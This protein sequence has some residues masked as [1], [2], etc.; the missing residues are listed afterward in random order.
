[1]QDDIPP[2]HRSRRLL[3][4]TL[5]GFPS[6][7]F[8]G[9][10]LGHGYGTKTTLHP[11]NSKLI[12]LIPALLMI[13]LIGCRSEVGRIPFTDTGSGK[14]EVMIDASKDVEFW[15]HLDLKEEGTDSLAEA[16]MAGKDVSLAY[17]ILLY[18]DGDLCS[19]LPAI[20][21]Q[22]APSIGA[23]GANL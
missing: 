16:I 5:L 19:D 6:K 17:S 22:S 15:T 23:Q 18:Q 2:M 11:M 7:W 20:P 10:A 8:F 1:M 14:T 21:S 3:S 13:A 4:L 12:L 9:R